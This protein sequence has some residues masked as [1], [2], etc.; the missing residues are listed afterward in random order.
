MENGLESELEEELGYIKYD[1]H[2]KTK[3]GS[4]NS[5]NGHSKKILKTSMGS[6]E[7][8]VPWNRNVEFEPQILEKIKS[9]SARM[10]KKKFS[11]CIKKAWP[12][13]I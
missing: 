8:D 1:Y 4:D 13:R 5:Q 11:L 9:I 3:S 6:V 12:Q 10:W 7:I 2:Q